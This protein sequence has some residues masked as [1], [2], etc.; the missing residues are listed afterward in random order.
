MIITVASLKGGVGK[1]T[2]AIHL[3]G[4]LQNQAKTLL[5][6]AD[7]NRSATAWSK[8]GDLPFVVIDEGRSLN[9]DQ[10]FD[11]LVIDTHAPAAPADLNVLAEHCDLMVIP[12]TPDVLALDALVL[13]LERLNS[14]GQTRYRVLLTMVPSKSSRDTDQV[15]TMLYGANVPLFDTAIRA[16]AAFPKAAQIGGLV[17]QVKDPRSQDAWHDY[18]QVGLELLTIFGL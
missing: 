16:F 15:R 11:H 1:T 3:A 17:T 7:P 10:P 9:P 5:I 4:F 8:R 14:L 2:T 12:T 18:Q 6:D 13:L